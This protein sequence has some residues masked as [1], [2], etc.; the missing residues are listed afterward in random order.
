MSKP[1]GW[2]SRALPISL[3]VLKN[4][5]GSENQEK[6]LQTKKVFPHEGITRLGIDL[7]SIELRVVEGLLRA[8]AETQNKGNVDPISLK[9]FEKACGGASNIKFND[10]IVTSPRLKLTQKKLFQLAGIKDNSIADKQRA[11][12]A[13]SKISQKRYQIY[14]NRLSYDENG[15]PSKD[16]F[17]NWEKEFVCGVVT[18]FNIYDVLSE[19]TNQLRYYEI[20]LNPVFLDQIESYFILIPYEWRNELKKASGGKRISLQTQ[21]F[22]LYLMWQ[23]ELRR[24]GKKALNHS[25]EVREHWKKIA[26]IIRIASSDMKEHKKRVITNLKRAYEIAK[27]A[28]YLLD[29]EFDEDIHVLKLNFDKFISPSQKQIFSEKEDLLIDAPSSKVVEELFDFFYGQKRF[30]DPGCEVP[31]GSDKKQQLKAIVNI[32]KKRSEEDFKNAVSWGLKQRFWGAKISSPLKLGEHFDNVIV[33]MNNSNSVELV[34]LRK[35]F[36]KK[37]KQSCKNKNS[38]IFFDILNQKIEIGDGVY[39]DVIFYTD[40]CFKESLLGFLE[41]WGFERVDLAED[42]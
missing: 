35:R 39:S 21:L 30:I 34:N 32:L 5:L 42:L 1:E 11:V 15:K 4:I 14:Y 29:F 33:E 19:E 36:A 37:L 9:D 26:R 17:G 2:D 16:R 7:S 28:G 12:S 22:M 10:K 20:H 8:F 31:K 38:K 41:K 40:P 3:H 6:L 18:L 23:Y 25:N 13:L 27:T 24:R